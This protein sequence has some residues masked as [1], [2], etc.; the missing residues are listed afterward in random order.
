LPDG[1][2]ETLIW[3]PRYDFNWQLTYEFVEP[4]HTPRGTR[5]EMV[6]HHDNSEGNPHNPVL[7]PVDVGW[8]LASSD[9]M[10]F[11]GIQYTL[12]SEQLG[13]TPRLPESSPATGGE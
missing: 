10:S 13:I 7:P 5:F 2:R 6:S 8:G 9:E 12:D 1:A 4:L 3:V 11:S